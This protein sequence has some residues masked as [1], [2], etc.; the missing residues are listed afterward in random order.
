MPGGA[1]ATVRWAIAGR[2]QKKLDGMLGGLASPPTGVVINTSDEASLRAMSA[3]THVLM[4]AT[5]RIPL[6]R[7][8]GGERL[9]RNNDGLL[10][11]VR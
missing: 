4:N 3:R 5:G 1:W 2:S 7:R 10:R 6:L 9:H 11:P 8:G